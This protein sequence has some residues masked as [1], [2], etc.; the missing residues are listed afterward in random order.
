MT[1]S[2]SHKAIGHLVEPAT[3]SDVWMK[4]SPQVFES[5]VRPGGNVYALIRGA[6]NREVVKIDVSASIN[7]MLKVARGQGGTTANAWPAGALL[8]NSTN[9]DHYN[10]IIQLGENRTIDYNPN[11][12]LAPLY[13]GEKIY[14]NAPAGCERWWKAFNGVNPYWDIIT[15]EPCGEENYKDIG[16][17]YDLLIPADPWQKA[18]DLNDE[19]ESPDRVYSSVYDP[20]NHDLYVGTQPAQIWKSSDGGDTW[21]MIKEI[22]AQALS[23]VYCLC[24]NATDDTLFAGTGNDG[25]IWRS[26]DQGSTWTKVFDMTAQTPSESTCRSLIHDPYHDT[27][28]AGSGPGDALIYGSDDGG[29]TWVLK[30]NL[31][32]IWPFQDIVPA[33]AYEP[34]TH[35]I[36]VGTMP[37]SQIW[38]SDDGGDTWT[39]VLQED[40]QYLSS[41][42]YS[43]D[44]DA[45]LATHSCGTSSPAEIFKSL[46]GGDTWTLK[47]T[48]NQPTNDRTRASEL[49]YNSDNHWL[50]FST[51]QQSPWTDPY[52]AA[53]WISTD[54]G[55]NF[56]IDQLFYN[57]YIYALAYDSY[58]KVTIAGFWKSPSTCE[59]WKRRNVL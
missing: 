48:L 55:E 7:E 52:S 3:D 31:S 17:T 39:K 4:V 49:V 32:S 58:H 57:E 12:I 2:F 10:A 25:G 21:T 30:K 20:T 6:I 42:V 35:N 45:L 22:S 16:W 13:A 53:I 19:P 40:Y 28:V 50:H 54:G 51:V 56:T 29:D 37:S 47:Q 26:D 34:T 23:Y 27:M 38:L 18:F 59:V 36:V 9:E 8:F 15:G 24:H 44:E 43:A 11:E 33:I 46:D 1:I 41:L 14:Q 5:F